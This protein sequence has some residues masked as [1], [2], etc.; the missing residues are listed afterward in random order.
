MHCM[1]GTM[2]MRLDGTMMCLE[3]TRQM[4][5]AKVT[6]MTRMMKLRSRHRSC[7]RSYFNLFACLSGFGHYF[8]TYRL[9]SWIWALCLAVS[10]T[11][12]H[13]SFVFDSIVYSNAFGPYV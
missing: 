13:L 3:E 8:Q 4:M 9:Y 12:M 1:K 10:L 11:V 5:P 7:F 6:G 2:Q